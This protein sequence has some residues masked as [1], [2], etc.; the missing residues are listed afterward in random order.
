MW[1]GSRSRQPCGTNTHRARPLAKFKSS[2]AFSAEEAVAFGPG[3]L[4]FRTGDE[5]TILPH[6]ESGGAWVLAMCESSG[7]IAECVNGCHLAGWVPTAFLER[8]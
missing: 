6:P 7:D 3:I 2:N 4:Q 8:V 1:L 5:L